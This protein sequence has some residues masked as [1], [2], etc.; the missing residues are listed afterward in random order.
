M[1]NKSSSTRFLMESP[2]FEDLEELPSAPPTSDNSPAVT[3]TLSLTPRITA[4]DYMQSLPMEIRHK[5][6]GDLATADVLSFS[7]TSKDNR[8]IFFASL[9]NQYEIKKFNDMK[10]LRTLGLYTSH[11]TQVACHL[12][13]TAELKLLTAL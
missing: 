9:I 11:V 5:I 10:L 12:L 4:T 3:P 6:L 7:R 13:H 8:A 2:S 1:G